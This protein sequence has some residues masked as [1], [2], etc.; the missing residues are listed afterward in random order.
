MHQY[1]ESCEYFHKIGYLYIYRPSSSSHTGSI[2]KKKK[3][4]IYYI[5]VL[6][7]YTKLFNRTKMLAIQKLSNYINDKNFKYILQD[8]KTK[9]LI[10]SLIL[11]NMNDKSISIKDKIIFNISI[12]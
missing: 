6:Y 7:E 10:R 11:K 2:I 5:G 12:N 4:E 1:A 3:S 8:E 9:N